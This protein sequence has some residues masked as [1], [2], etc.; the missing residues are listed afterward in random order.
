MSQGEQKQAKRGDW[1]RMG[2]FILAIAAIVILSGMLSAI[3]TNP[4]IDGTAYGACSTKNPGNWCHGSVSAPTLDTLVTQCPCNK[5]PGYVQQGEGDSAACVLA[6]CD[7]GTSA[8]NCA[9]T[10]P[11][12]C[13]GGANYYDNATKCGCPSGT[14]ASGLFC[15][16]PPCNDGGTTV[17]NGVCSSKTIGKKCVNGN[18]VD[19]ASECPCTGTTTKVGEACVVV[20]NDGTQ[21]GECSAKK[22]KECTLTVSGTGYLKDNAGKCGCPEGQVASGSLC[23]DAG[24]LGGIGTGADVLGGNAPAANQSSEGT[25]SSALSCCC[26]P[27]AL[28]GIA[29][30]FVFSRKR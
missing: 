28:I 6:T 7:D 14:V 8:G 5:V 10:K 23:A 25:G 20:C 13:I 19:K 2:I 1:M 30:G 15:T 3:V 11:K 26:L 12:V 21:M 9:K 22:P 4:C 24:I 27:A 29:G 17:Q 16:Y 18:L